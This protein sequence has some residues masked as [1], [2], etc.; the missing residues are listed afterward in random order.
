[1]NVLILTDFS[2]TSENAGKYAAD[3]LQKT[4][5]NFYLLNIRSFDFNRSASN[6]LQ[7]ELVSTL[8]QLELDAKKLKKYSSNKE[9]KFNT[10]LSSENLISAVRKAL[11]EKKIDLIF[12]GAASQDEHAHPILGDHAYDVV[13]KIRCN[14]VAVPAGCK[15]VKPKKAVFPVDRS[16]LSYTEQK[17][18]FDELT[19]LDSSDFTLLEIKDGDLEYPENINDSSP[20]KTPVAFTKKLFLEIQKEYDIIFILGKNLSICDRLLHSEHGFSA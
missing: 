19:Y 9:H 4:S 3:F 13:R 1:M 6:A 16:I 10:I 8:G 15:Y 20:I 18:V 11:V 5:A 12:I 14:I 7:N 2:E 17:K